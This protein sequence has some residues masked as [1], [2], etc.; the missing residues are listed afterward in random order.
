M[1]KSTNNKRQVYEHCIT[2][3][4]YTDDDAPEENI[5]RYKINFFYIDVI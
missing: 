1:F 2:T 4:H 3:L 5:D